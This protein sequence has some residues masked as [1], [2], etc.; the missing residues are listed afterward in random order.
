MDALAAAGEG[1]LGLGLM[2]IHPAD[3]VLDLT[4]R[5]LRGIMP[6][7][8]MDLNAEKDMANVK[9]RLDVHGIRGTLVSPYP[10]KDLAALDR[11]ARRKVLGLG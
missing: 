4:A 1:V 6:L 3:E 2:G 11:T 5:L 7:M 9:A 8:I 10:G